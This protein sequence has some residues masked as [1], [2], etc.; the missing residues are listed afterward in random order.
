MEEYKNNSL[1]QYLESFI[2][3]EENQNNRFK[4]FVKQLK[5]N[6]FEAMKINDAIAGLIAYEHLTNINE[7]I[8]YVLKIY[9]EQKSGK[10]FIDKDYDLDENEDD[11]LTP[12]ALLSIKPEIIL[13]MFHIL[14]EPSFIDTS[15]QNILY[16]LRENY[17]KFF[18]MIDTSIVDVSIDYIAYNTAKNHDLNEFNYAKQLVPND[19]TTL[20]KIFNDVVVKACTTFEQM[21]YLSEIYQPIVK[22]TKNEEKV[23]EKLQNQLNDLNNELENKNMIIQKLNNKLDDVKN[24]RNRYVKEE[25]ENLQETIAKLNKQIKLLKKENEELKSLKNI[26][27]EEKIEDIKIEKTKEINFNQLRILFIVSNDATFA[28][29]LY[30]SFHNCKVEYRN[31]KL[32]FTKYDYVIAITSH[33]DHATYGTIKDKCKN[34][35]TKFLHCN[36]TNVE[37]I[38]ELIKENYN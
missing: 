33:I 6:M 29:D 14:Y 5:V 11:W 27:I 34:S 2:R 35:N 12:S 36:N 31:Y 17:E 8:L 3:K 37:K 28:N 7:Y 22:E 30:E 20:Y 24:S 32:D 21:L 16:Y 18:E 9:Y 19:V 4:R 26:Q 1:N 23:N 13:K 25:T 38:K 15:P 10:L